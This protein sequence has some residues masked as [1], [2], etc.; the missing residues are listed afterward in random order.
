M[1]RAAI[2]SLLTLSL[3]LGANY[4]TRY[5]TRVSYTWFWGGAANA[6]ADRDFI[7]FTVSMDF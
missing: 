4:L 5:R 3:A 7:S 1:S 2:V 6:L